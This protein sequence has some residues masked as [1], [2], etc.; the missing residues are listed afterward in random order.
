[1]TRRKVYDCP[2]P[3]CGKVFVSFQS[4]KEHRK[5]HGG[6]KYMCTLKGCGK[7]FKWRSSLASHKRAHGLINES[8]KQSEVFVD[9]EHQ[10]G[11]DHTDLSS[12]VSSLTIPDRSTETPSCRM[13]GRSAPDSPVSS[14]RSADSTPEP[15]IGDICRILSRD[16]SSRED[17]PD[18]LLFLFTCDQLSPHCLWRL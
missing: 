7:Y 9:L 18:N 5:T 4:I 1:M 16:T 13:M 17:E 3:G 2:E 10:M 6:P 15:K 14:T 11:P 8:R 12:C